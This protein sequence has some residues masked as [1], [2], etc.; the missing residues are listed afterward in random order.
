MQSFGAIL[1]EQAIAAK[2]YRRYDLAVITD[3]LAQTEADR[4]PGEVRALKVTGAD[5]D[6]TLHLASD[7]ATA[8][9]MCYDLSGILTRINSLLGALAV[10]HL[11]VVHRNTD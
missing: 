10:D 6:R 2:R 1:D 3:V 7:S 4:W 8:L 11:K 5:G 9:L